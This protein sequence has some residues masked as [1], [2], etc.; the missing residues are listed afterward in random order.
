M[1]QK[2]KPCQNCKADFTIEPEDFEFYEKIQVPEPTFCSECR[3]KRRMSWRNEN[4]V[5]KRKC[6]FSGEEIFSMHSPTSEI[7]VYDNDIWW[8]DKW[9]P[10]D[11][12]REYNFEKS[13]FE[14]FDKLKNEVPWASRS[15]L[16]SVD[17]DYCINC[18]YLKKCYFVFSAG[19]SEDCAYC[20]GISFTKDCFDCYH[21]KKSELCYKG[22]MLSNCYKTFFSSHCEDCQEIWFCNNCT[23]CHDCFGC[24]NLKHKKYHIFNKEYSKEKYFEILAD[25]NL[26]SFKTIKEAEKKFKEFHLKFP[27]KFINGK[28]NNDITGE[29]INNCKNVFDSYIAEDTED[30]KYVQFSFSKGNKD[31]YDTIVTGMTAILVYECVVAGDGVNNIKFCLESFTKSRN[32]EYCIHCH[33]CSDCFGCV[34][35]RHKQYCILNKQYTKE[36]Y[37]KLVP[38]IKQHMNDMPYT[39]SQGNTYKYGEF[40]PPELSPFAYN[41]TIAQEYFPLKKEEAIKKG[42]RWY[43]KPKSKYKPTIKAKDLPDHIKDVDDSILKE[44]IECNSK[45]CKGSEVYRIIPKELEFYK[46]QNLPLPRLCPDCRHHERIKQRNPMKLYERVCMKEGL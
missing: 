38:K 35:L 45:E 39:D 8:S 3:M 46:N 20:N 40:F 21:S 30:S 22:F 34:S 7:K 36:E 11:F 29:Y 17:S 19:N 6:D 12:G 33:S 43:D 24:I 42:Y 1:N 18:V 15:I 28:K 31:C 32:L 13:F 26:G 10:L 25:L 9:N 27:V 44:V 37:E 16:G 41:E 2:T 14:Q 23:N 5:Y 4:K